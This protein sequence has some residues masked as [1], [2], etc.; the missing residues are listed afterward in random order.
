MGHISGK[1]RCRPDGGTSGLH[2]HRPCVCLAAILFLFPASADEVKKTG[3]E[4]RGLTN[5]R[6][7]ATSDGAKASAA[8][9]T[10]DY[11]LDGSIFPP[12]I[13]PPTFLWRDSDRSTSFWRIEVSFADGS[14]VI[15]ALSKGEHMRVGRIDP[16]CVAETNELPKLT[17]QQA[18]A[19][20]WIPDARIWEFIKQHS[21]TA[22]A[23][24]EITGYRSAGTERPV[25]RGRVTIH[26]SPDPVGAPIF[27][28]DVPLMPTETEKGNIK[29]LAPYAVRL[30]RW[31]LRN[32]DE[33]QS[34]VLLENL[35]MCANCHSF[36]GD[37]KTLGMDLDGLQNNKGRYTLSPVRPEVSIGN[38]NVIQWSTARGVLKS[39]IRVGFMSQV[40][41]HGEYVVTT[42]DVPDTNQGLPSVSSPAKSPAN[43]S[44]YYVANFK[45]YKFLQVF[46]PTRGTLAWYSRKTGILQPLPGADDSRY[47]QMGGVWS[48]DGKYLVFARAN[49]KEPN[50][51]GAPV[52]RFANDPNERQIQYDLYRIPFD[53]GKGGRAEPI[54][55][56]SQNGKSNSF[57]KV[58]PDGRWIVFVQSRNGLLMRP[59][60]QLFI[61]P[62][63]G[64]QARRMRCNTPLMNS[65]HSFSPNGRWL[66]F[67]SKSR[68]PYTQMY[69][70]HIDPDGNDSPPI[71]IEN[72]TAA[73]RAVNIP[74][75]VNV[76]RGGL[77]K[78]GGP[79]IEY[80]RLV[81]RAV[82]LRKRGRY[83][84][85]VAKW[86]QALA[87]IPDDT[88]SLSNLGA[89]LLL[90]GH[91]EDAA[92]NL[93]RAK[94]VRLDESAGQLRK[95]LEYNPRSAQTSY[96]L[97]RVLA[98]KGET[99]EAILQWQATL[100]LDPAFAR[101]HTSLGTAL[102]SKGRTA[103]ALAHWR[104]GIRLL[105]ED[106]PALRQM[107]WVLATCPEASVRNG[108]EALELAQRA[109]RLSDGKDALV[110]DTLA[111]AYAE[112][113]RFTDALPAARRALE[114]A[115]QGNEQGEAEAVRN[116]IALFE[117]GKP[118]REPQVPPVGP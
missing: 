53:D 13:T 96:D 94:E 71:L 90:T 69:L 51:E 22:A 47:V 46:Y 102:Y 106:F 21:V 91:P 9:I 104:E 101:A 116:R 67:S 111:A 3:A 10:I 114:L 31:R 37:G 105:P 8:A 11:P 62:A 33:P 109:E 36:S 1:R 18:A 107:A 2:R 19:R 77:Q 57:P 85:S 28:R 112:L 95:E 23:T 24:V 54:A 20:T 6:L 26:T 52:A 12:E 45:N 82:Y 115:V 43:T 68:S 38:G 92:A 49:A 78:I 32:V 58:S 63:N 84:E 72:S 5:S 50:P 59:D 7:A 15:G 73:N 55:G 27:Y 64:G 29:P 48:P 4:D 41:P 35:P 39:R 16:S 83:E 93:K 110:F 76:P 97:G 79:A 56:A 44:N 34:H 66:V 60:S 17:P 75:F 70:T 80:F 113:G 42:I 89:L 108:A 40:S 61:V 81:D 117:S 74:E 86:K 65:W 30:I 25:S 103:E 118:F 88:V 98:E 87:L 99:E 14:P 100:K